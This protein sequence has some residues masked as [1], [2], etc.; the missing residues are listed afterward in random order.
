M[1]KLMILFFLI[2]SIGLNVTEAQ[3]SVGVR[4]GYPPVWAPRAYNTR[5][6]YIPELDAYYDASRGGYYV[7]NG[8]EDWSYESTL[9]GYYGDVDFS[10]F[11]PVVVNYWGARPWGYFGRYRLGY[12]RSYHPGWGSYGWYRPRGERFIGGRFE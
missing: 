8:S 7:N 1:K 2:T 5:Y 3:V 4:I 10:L 11:H 9:P 12:V 6:Y